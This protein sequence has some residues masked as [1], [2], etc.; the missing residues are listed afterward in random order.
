[1]PTQN[2]PQGDLT[3]QTVAMPADTNSN[4]DIF[5]GWI[6][7]QMDLAA[8]VTAARISQGRITTVAIDSMVFHKPVTIGS[9]VSVY[10]RLLKTG[11]TSM[12]ID[13]DVWSTNRAKPMPVHVTEGQFIFVAID[14]DG[15]KRKLPI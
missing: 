1:M 11:T 7:S 15:N 9:V 2:Q 10:T 6:L 12:T 14:D 13:V 4:G 5:G 8:G 3:I